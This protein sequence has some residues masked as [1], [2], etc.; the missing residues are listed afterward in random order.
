MPIG[1]FITNKHNTN[2]LFPI[3]STYT[4]L[5][6]F[7]RSATIKHGVY[8]LDD[9]PTIT[10]AAVVANRLVSATVDSKALNFSVDTYFNSLTISAN[11][12]LTATAAYMKVLRVLG[13]MTLDSAKTLTVS[14]AVG[15]GLAIYVAGDLAINGTITMSGL[16]NSANLASD[17]TLYGSD[18]LPNVGRSGGAINSNGDDA[19]AANY[20]CGSGG[21]GYWD[22]YCGG[23]T[24]GATSYTFGGGAGGTSGYDASG[25]ITVGGTAAGGVVLIFCDGSVSG[26]GAIYAKGVNGSGGNQSTGGGGRIHVFYRGTCSGPTISA[27]AGTPTVNGKTGGAGYTDTT[28]IT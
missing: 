4:T 21:G 13:N 18:V 25:C 11:L 23:A 12:T 19:D 16:A 2:Y 28:Q 27:A 5:Y 7:M 9:L 22:T 1:G 6:E 10:T 3:D 15:Y 14:S 17:L 20:S 26:S 8:T 24:A